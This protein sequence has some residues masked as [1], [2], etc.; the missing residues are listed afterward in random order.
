M[1]KGVLD[2]GHGLRD[3]AI[4]LDNLPL[5]CSKLLDIA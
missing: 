4:V 5:E 2:A 3:R 1:F